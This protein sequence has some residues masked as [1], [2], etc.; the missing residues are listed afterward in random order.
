MVPGSSMEKELVGGRGLTLSVLSAKASKHKG[1]D[2]DLEMAIE[3]S[4]LLRNAGKK[5]NLDSVWSE[6]YTDREWYQEVPGWSRSA[7]ASEI[8]W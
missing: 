5:W 7:L 6:F 8:G 3:H 2:I 4:P 1:F